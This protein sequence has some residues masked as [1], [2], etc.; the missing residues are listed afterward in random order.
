MTAVETKKPGHGDGNVPTP[1]Y[2]R[3]LG[4][5]YSST[6]LYVYIVWLLTKDRTN[7]ETIPWSFLTI[8]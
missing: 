8:P 3:G 6:P 7:Y 2:C 4:F 5:D 1:T